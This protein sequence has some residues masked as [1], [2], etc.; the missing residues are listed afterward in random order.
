MLMAPLDR[1]APHFLDDDLVLLELFEA[2]QGVSLRLKGPQERLAVAAK[3]FANDRGDALIHEIIRNLVSLR[4][5]LL[6]D[7]LPIDEIV[8]GGKADLLD[9][10]HRGP[11]PSIGP[12]SFFLFSPTKSRIC[13]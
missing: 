6:E 4:L 13:P 3:F 7:E 8:D 5:E 2:L 12:G 1:I 10:V 9:L 11:R